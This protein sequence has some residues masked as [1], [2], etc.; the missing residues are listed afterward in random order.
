MTLLSVSALVRES[1][2]LFYL[3]Y[4]REI[5]CR[6]GAPHLLST[7]SNLPR[8]SDYPSWCYSYVEWTVTGIE[9][10][11][12][13]STDWASQ[14]VWVWSGWKMWSLP[15]VNHAIIKKSAKKQNLFF[16]TGENTPNTST[17]FSNHSSSWRIHMLEFIEKSELYIICIYV[18]SSL[19]RC[20]NSNRNCLIASPIILPY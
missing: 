14:P 12:F 11:T 20:I 3:C 7:L 17:Y 15:C 10:R 18:F 13:R 4:T 6:S 16:L 2:P 8:I 9:P 19:V 1:D 5:D